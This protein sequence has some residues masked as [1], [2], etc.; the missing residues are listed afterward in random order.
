VAI[1]RTDQHS[2]AALM[3]GLKHQHD[4]GAARR[5]GRRHDIRWRWL[6]LHRRARRKS[7]SWGRDFCQAHG[8]V[9]VFLGHDNQSVPTFAKVTLT[10][11]PSLIR[12]VTISDRLA[13][14]CPP[15]PPASLP[16]ARLNS[17]PTYSGTF[18]TAQTHSQATAVFG[19]K[20]DS[21]GF[22]C[23]SDLP[24]GGFA[25][26]E[27][28]VYRLKPSNCRFGYSRA[29]CQITL[30]PSQQRSSRFDLPRSNQGAAPLL[31]EILLTPRLPY[32][33]SFSITSD[34]NAYKQWRDEWRSICLNGEPL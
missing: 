5:R 18:T 30:R 31:I 23:C 15:L 29:S 7:R 9:A 32:I 34:E 4:A 19:N 16:R 10:S 6:H 2:L 17:S 20:I 8:P 14:Q 13:D 11:R 28:P 26:T 27:F 21:S 24:H 3:L 25:P 1:G 22:D 33:N 12:H